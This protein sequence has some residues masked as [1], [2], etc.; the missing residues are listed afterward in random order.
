[1]T[2]IKHENIVNEPMGNKPVGKL[3]GVGPTL[4]GRMVHGGYE[5][6]SQIYGQYLVLN[7]DHVRFENWMKDN[8]RAD[9][10]HA[11]NCS[12]ALEEYYTHFN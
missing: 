8:F 7:R 3:P 6:A 10:R 5:K 11:G 12:K 4:S 9:R 2:T 1:M